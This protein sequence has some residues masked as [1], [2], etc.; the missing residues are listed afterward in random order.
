[1]IKEKKRRKLKGKRNE[2]KAEERGKKVKRKQ[3]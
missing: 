3:K 1:M 2:M